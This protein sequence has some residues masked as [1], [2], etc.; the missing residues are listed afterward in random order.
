MKDS[1]K[2]WLESLDPQVRAE[3]EAE[4]ADYEDPDN[5]EIDYDPDWKP[6]PEGGMGLI[7]DFNREEIKTLTKAF[8]T[9]TAMFTIM[10][11]AL[12]KQANEII[13]QRDE[14]NPDAAAAD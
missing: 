2:L 11:D 7:V 12:M 10:H 14:A 4:I 6:R 3:V 8:G 9:D 1:Q 5:W 13:A